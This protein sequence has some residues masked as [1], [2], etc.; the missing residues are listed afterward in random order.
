MELI[1]TYDSN[2]DSNS[3]SDTVNSLSNRQIRSVYLITY[4]Q[5]DITTFPTRESFANA[6]T[7]KF[8]SKPGI[9]VINWV[10][11][12]E[13][14]KKTGEHY[15]LALK[16]NKVKRWLGIKQEFQRDFNVV[17]HFS[18]GHSNYFSAYRYVTKSDKDFVLS[19]NHPDLSNPPRTMQASQKRKGDNSDVPPK[20]VIKRLSNTDISTIVLSKHIKTNQQLYAL[21]DLQKEEG[22]T[23]LYAFLLSRGEKKI[24]DLLKMTWDIANSQENVVRQSKTRLEILSD[25][26]IKC[27]CQW[28]ESALQVLRRNDIPVA[29]FSESLKNLLQYGRGKYRNVMIV[30]PANCG[31][32]FILK[33]VT[34]IYK[35][36]LNPAS[37][38][39]A[40]VGVQLCEAIFLNDFRWSQ[41]IIPWHDFLLLLEG[42]TVHLPAP[43]TH[44]SEDITLTSH[45][46][47]F[48]TSGNE[49]KYGSSKGNCDRENEMMAV[50]W[51]VF[52]FHY[53]MT[54]EEQKIIPPCKHCFA[55]L[56]LQQ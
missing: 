42:E 18:D 51:N 5:A 39:F 13:Q 43:K 27:D 12:R 10:C 14:H 55:K 52:Q 20:K 7:E 47:I 34:E 35:C 53:V 22:K 56:V 41:Q 46:P 24:S 40:W 54:E 29:V 49:I 2:T 3:E 48:A 15:H 33:P 11:C 16:L 1:K 9:T 50:R 26:L 31:K 28:Y 23:D 25:H 45:L 17:L 6:V 37:S 36:F 21:A 44:F 19:E 30:G 4:S 8:A 32:T 38:T